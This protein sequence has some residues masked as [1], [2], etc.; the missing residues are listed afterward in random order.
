[1]S[2]SFGNIAVSLPSFCCRVLT[3]SGPRCCRTAL[4]SRV[5]VSWDK[6]APGLVVETMTLDL[7]MDDVQRV[8]SPLLLVTPG[9]C[10]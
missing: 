1:M 7:S 5:L 4:Y 9:I 6:A 8:A 2:P 10:L 3:D